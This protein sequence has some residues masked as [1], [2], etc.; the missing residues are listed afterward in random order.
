MSLSGK[1]KNTARRGKFHIDSEVERY[2][3]H[4]LKFI[5]K[6]QRGKAIEDYLRKSK[7]AKLHIGAGPNQLREWLNT[8]LTPRTENAIFLD[9]T[10]PFPFQN[11]TFDYIYTEHLIEHISYSEG[12]EMLKECFRILKP[13]GKLRIATPDFDVFMGLGCEGKNE[14]QARYIEWYRQKYLQQLDVRP[15]IYIINSIFHNWGHQFVYDKDSLER[16]MTKAGFKKVTR[17]LPGKS[18]DSVFFG[19]EHHGKAI[20]SESANRFETMVLEAVK[21]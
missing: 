12:Q 21:G 16:S 14:E 11:A 10:E 13:G 9:A 19:I 15:D 20:G 18:D 5:W 4:F 3:S 6:K 8:D 1:A 17:C 2:R 7:T